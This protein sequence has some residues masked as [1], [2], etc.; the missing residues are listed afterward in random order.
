[1]IGRWVTYQ[2]YLERQLNNLLGITA[3]RIPSGFIMDSLNPTG[4]GRVQPNLRMLLGDI[5]G[6]GECN[7]PQQRNIFFIVCWGAPLVYPNLHKSMKR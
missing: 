4:S 6:W 1:M 7:E 3:Y 5:V 2:V